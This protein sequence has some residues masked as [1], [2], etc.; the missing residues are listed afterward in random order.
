M[1]NNHKYCTDINTN[2]VKCIFLIQ[3]II[4]WVANY[5]YSYLLTAWESTET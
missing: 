4:S 1:N 2:S 3:L 5:I